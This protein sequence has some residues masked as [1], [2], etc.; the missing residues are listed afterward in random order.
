M[1]EIQIGKEEVKLSLLADDMIFYI[2]SP[3]DTTRKSLEL[4]DD[5]SKVIGQKIN[6]QKSLAFIYTKIEK[7]Q[8]EIKETITFTIAMKRKNT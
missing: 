4:I 5:Y 2:E 8:E 3:K 1:K 7:Q 6:A